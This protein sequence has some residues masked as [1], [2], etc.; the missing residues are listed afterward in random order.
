LILNG[1]TL[2][3]RNGGS[4]TLAGTGISATAPGVGIMTNMPIKAGTVNVANGVV[5]SL[6]GPLQDIAGGLT[7]T[8]DGTL[9]ISAQSE[10]GTFKASAGTVN[11]NS[12]RNNGTLALPSGSTARVNIGPGVKVATA[13]FS[14]G[15]GT[16]QATP[17]TSALNIT[18]TLKLAGGMMATFTGGTSF[19][20]TGDN[21]ANSNS[22]KTL[23]L[24][25]GS[26]A[27]AVGSGGDISYSPDGGTVIHTFRSPGALDIPR[28]VAASVLVVGGG[29][30]GGW[31]CGGGGGGGGLIYYGSETPE[32]GHPY[33]TSYAISPGS[34]PVT[35]G[36]G[37]SGA[38]GPGSENVVKNGGDS[39]LGSLIAKGGGGGA[40]HAIQV[41]IDAGAGSSGGSGGGGTY[42]DFKIVGQQGTP[43]SASDVSPSPPQGYAGGSGWILTPSGP[44][45]G[46]GGG[47]AGGLG[48]SATDNQSVGADGGPGLQYAI[49]G[50]AAYYA[51][52][53]GGGTHEYVA[54]A[55]GLGGG[56]GGG[57]HLISSPT[58]FAGS[59]GTA[60]TGGGGGGGSGGGGRGGSGGSG[61]VIV[62]YPR[63][64]LYLPKTT[65]AAT[66]SS[67]LDLG[68]GTS[69]STLGGL[70]L[71][72]SG[73][74]LVVIGAG[75]LDLGALT[76]DHG[77]LLLCDTVALR[78]AS[79]DV[80][81]RITAESLTKVD[82][83]SPGGGTLTLRGGNNDIAGGV[84]VEKGTLE[85]ANVRALPVGRS[86]TI[87]AG[88][89]VVL[90][91]G[92]SVAGASGAASATAPVPEPG[93]IA[94]LLAG[95]AVLLA[96]RRRGIRR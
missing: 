80:E 38:G 19:A 59:D 88:G 84:T 4:L 17:A 6:S 72:G 34:T 65:I 27:F 42:D 63:I 29:G 32:G 66:A 23:T 39:S 41:G 69:D 33:G 91:S 64:G 51:G 87:A 71:S 20:A 31:E 78:V 96:A 44:G 8:G 82:D 55:G 53:G 46:G 79:G 57:E 48:L 81:G 37:G 54:G 56:G 60:N 94:L 50:K 93:T 49:S 25:G 95:A 22:P 3:I 92:L 5:L 7:K 24:S 61:I 47:G 26:L 13:D 67:I 85:I 9:T 10:F 62:S 36:A 70:S 83:G 86:L 76:G 73:T 11:F 15:V 18:S 1:G 28:S 68:S 90:S 45:T 12:T 75:S 14:A 35:V 58:A 89:T 43:G 30:G 52:G 21:L 74:E 16:V 77:S 2:T 40:H